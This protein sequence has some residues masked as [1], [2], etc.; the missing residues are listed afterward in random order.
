V[1]FVVGSLISKPFPFHSE[2]NS[3][4]LEQIYTYFALIYIDDETVYFMFQI[5]MVE[6]FV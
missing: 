5:M 6:I 4:I 1:K 2:G 3:G